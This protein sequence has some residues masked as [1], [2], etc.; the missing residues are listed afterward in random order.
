[1][2]GW[3]GK[4]KQSASDMLKLPPDALLSTPRVT[5]LDAKTVIVENATRLLKVEEDQVSLE[6]PAEKYLIVTGRD[7]EVT[8]VTNREVHLS[9]SVQK[10]EFTD[11]GRDGE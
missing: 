5:C 3:K 1:M 10:L 11:T 9:G 6:L 7:F 8:L 4:L 2:Q